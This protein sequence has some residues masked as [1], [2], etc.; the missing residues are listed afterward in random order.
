MAESKSFSNGRGHWIL[1]INI[2]NDGEGIICPLI[3]E[4]A[5]L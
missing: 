4:R 2:G 3:I 5:H 1:L